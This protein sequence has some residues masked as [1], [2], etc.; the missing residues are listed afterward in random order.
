M[1]ALSAMSS[2][3]LVSQDDRGTDT[4]GRAFVTRRFYRCR[5]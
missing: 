5:S 4:A 2:N 1:S 3:M